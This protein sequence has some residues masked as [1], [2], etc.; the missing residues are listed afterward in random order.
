[1]AR[2]QI[3][4]DAPVTAEIAAVA[5]LVE[6]DPSRDRARFM[7]EL[8]RLLYTQ[9]SQRTPALTLLRGGKPSAARDPASLASRVPVPLTAASWSRAVFRRPIEADQL[10]AAIISM[11][12]SLFFHVLAHLTMTR[13]SFSRSTSTC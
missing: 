1:M 7:A 13:S 4:E 11:R 3:A 5:R 12:A 10:V 8:T 9:P 2:S 6:M